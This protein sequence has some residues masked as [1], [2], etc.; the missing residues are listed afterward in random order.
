MKKSILMLFLLSGCTSVQFVPSKVN[1][2]YAKR[3]EPAAIELFR[4]SSPT[5]K[6]FEIGAT[7]ACCSTDANSMI[8]LLRKQASESGGDAL[9]GLDI[10]AKGGASATVVRY[11]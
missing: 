6:F 7:A 5:K 4:S 10:S 3:T 2:V 11:E 1:Q 9:M 8:E